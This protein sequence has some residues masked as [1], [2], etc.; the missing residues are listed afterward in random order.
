M[1]QQFFGHP[2]SP[3][4]GVYH[5]PAQ[6]RGDRAPRAVLICPPIGQEYNRTH[7]A[8][9]LLANQLTRKGIHVLRLDYHGIGDSSQDVDQIDSLN[10]WT[11]NIDQAITHLKQ[12]SGAETVMLL[13]Q[14]FG[15]TLAAMV[16]RQRPDVN[17]LVLWEPV[18]DGSAYLE[19]LRT[20]HAQMLD[21]WVCKMRTP[22]DQHGEEILGSLYSPSLLNEIE[23]TR[24]DLQSIVQPQ[25]IVDVQSRASYYAHAEPSLQKYL[26]TADPTSWFDLNELETACL[27]SETTRVIVQLV[28]EMF[29]RLE[30]FGALRILTQPLESEGGQ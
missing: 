23:T 4:F 30:H 13:G 21:L 10:I 19:E 5:R 11:R 24:L 12:T 2:E 9:R 18:S 14:R 8:L 17:S 22:N 6:V 27:R 25:L 20:M 29:G 16:T 15:G 26:P 3:L 28:D 7:W 1:N